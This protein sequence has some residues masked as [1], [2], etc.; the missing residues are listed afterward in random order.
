[1]KKLNLSSVK[2]YNRFLKLALVA[3]FAIISITGY[4]QTRDYG[5]WTGAE[6]SQK[7]N[8]RLSFNLAG[9]LRLRDTLSTLDELLAEL[10]VGIKINS[11]FDLFG[12]YRIGRSNEDYGFITNHRLTLGAKTD[13]DISRFKVG[14][15]LRYEYE[16]AEGYYN[17]Y[18]LEESKRIRSKVSLDYNLP[19]TKVSPYISAELFYDMSPYKE[20]EFSKVRYRVGANL[21]VNK[22]NA[23]EIFV[24]YQKN[25]NAKTRKSSIVLGLFYSF[26]MKPKAVVPEENGNAGVAE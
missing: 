25:L 16:F 17:G 10:G 11:H 18:N 15:N 13:W 1:L 9:E 19:K 5:L 12:G 24:Q 22:R 20:H 3:G 7:V 2:R 26:A 21:P 6:V 23:W 4:A 8:K 14:Y